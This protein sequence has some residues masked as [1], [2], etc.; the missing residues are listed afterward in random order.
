[1]ACDPKLAAAAGPL[2]TD[3]AGAELVR[4]TH[5]AILAMTEDIEAFHFNKAVA[6]LYTLANAIGD[7]REDSADATVA[8]RFAVESLTR[9]LAPMAP[10]IAE[11]MW[12]SLGHDTMLADSAW[13]EADPSI[14]TEA[15]IEIGVQVNGKLRDTVSLPLDV[16]E[17]QARA[18]ALAS[19]GV[20]RYLDGSEPKKVIVVKNRIINVVV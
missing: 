4:A 13:P 17:D 5:R 10:H 1:M 18:A 7:L 3:G 15:N 2:P 12:E 14:V 6:Q 8:R 11:E 9:L 20:L 16:D 19:A